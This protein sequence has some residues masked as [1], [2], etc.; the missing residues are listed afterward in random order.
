MSDLLTAE[1]AA[2]LLHLHVKRV[3][4][5]ARAGT[6]PAIRHGR[7]WL[8]RRSDILQPKSRPPKSL[9]SSM[10]DSAVEISARNRLRGTITELRTDQVMTEVH[11]AV[12]DQSIVSVITTSSAARLDL[13]VG[14]E[15]LAVVKATEVMIARTVERG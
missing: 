11:I 7:K 2:D 12:G 14:D 4:A 10:D 9:P 5:L 8:F 6:L 15:V 1:Q 13:A 3:Q